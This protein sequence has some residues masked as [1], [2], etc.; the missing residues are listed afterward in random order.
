[1][2]VTSEAAG[3]GKTASNGSGRKWEEILL[4]W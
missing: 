4:F 3:K 2:H 1:M